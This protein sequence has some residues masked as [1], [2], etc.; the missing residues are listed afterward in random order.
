MSGF[1]HRQDLSQK[2]HWNWPEKMSSGPEDTEERTD[3]MDG[4]YV[5]LPATKGSDG[6]G[7]LSKAWSKII[8]FWNSYI[9]KY[10]ILLIV[11]NLHS[12]I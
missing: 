8:K 11:T 9:M 2:S 6:C 10:Q 5:N 4:C 7:P 1:D 12:K 3:G